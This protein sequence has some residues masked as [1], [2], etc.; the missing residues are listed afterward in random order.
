[1]PGA[2]SP[3]ASHKALATAAATVAQVRVCRAI[4]RMVVKSLDAAQPPGIPKTD[5]EFVAPG[6]GS[7]AGL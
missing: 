3:E 6:P 1:V 4:G 2:A 5:E 7:E